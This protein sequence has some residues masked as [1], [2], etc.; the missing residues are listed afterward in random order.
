MTAAAAVD[1]VIIVRGNKLYN[2]NTGE[3]FFIKGLTYEYAVSDEYYDKYSKATIAENLAGLQYNTLRLYNINPESS[4]K[5]F[6][7]D[8][9]KLGVYVMVSAS[10]DND[11]YYGKYRYS[12]ITKKLSC[13]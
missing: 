4:Y 1:G 13:T 3:R 2:A 5:K 10:P 6:M 8:M 9:A 12:T 11:A 7:A